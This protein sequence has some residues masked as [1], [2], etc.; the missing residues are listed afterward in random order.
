MRSLHPFL[1]FAVASLGLLQFF[2]QEALAQRGMCPLMAPALMRGCHPG[3]RS[4]VFPVQHP[5]DCLW[6]YGRTSLDSGYG[7]VYPSRLYAGFSSGDRLGYD[8]SMTS[9]VV[10]YYPVTAL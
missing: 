6:G 2:P 9:D 7:R 5:N 8:P 10:P 1:I 3:F 4:S